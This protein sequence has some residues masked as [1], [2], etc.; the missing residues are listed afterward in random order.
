MGS[1]S[2]IAIYL[3][4]HRGLRASVG[5]LDLGGVHVHLQQYPAQTRADCLNEITASDLRS[6]WEDVGN[7]IRDSLAKGKQ[8]L[9]TQ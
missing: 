5:I 4:R 7:S 2:S 9:V 1:K 6:V 8:E 3:R